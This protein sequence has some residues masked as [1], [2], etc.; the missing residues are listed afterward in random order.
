MTDP[1]GGIASKVAEEMAKEVQ[2]AMRQAEQ[3]TQTQEVQGPKFAEH[4]Q[5][6]Q[7]RDPQPVSYTHLTLPTSDL[8]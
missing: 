4:L 6:Q 3:A 7:V 5:L 2:T 1:T 8:V